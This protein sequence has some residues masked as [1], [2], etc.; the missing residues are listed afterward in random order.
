MGTY[1]VAY[2]TIGAMFNGFERRREPIVAQQKATDMT[3]SVVDFMSRHYDYNRAKVKQFFRM[4]GENKN[5]FRR[6]RPSREKRNTLV[7]RI[8]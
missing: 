8:C 1:G 2:R 5:R 4:C 3:G 6:E 7:A